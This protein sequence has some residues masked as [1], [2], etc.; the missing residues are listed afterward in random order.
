MNTEVLQQHR[1]IYLG[2]IKELID[3]NTKALMEDDL[4]P[5]FKTPPL[6]AMDTIKQKLLSLAKTY[7]IV[8]N[9]A[10]FDSVL[11][12]YRKKLVDEVKLLQEKRIAVLT[13]KIDQFDALD[14]EQIVKTLKKELVKLDKEIK[15]DS[16]EFLI[17]INEDVLLLQMDCLFQDF[18]NI[19]KVKK[20]FSKYL[21]GN[22][23]KQIIETIDMKLLVKDTTLLNVLKEQV[24]RFVF[25]T[26]NSHLFD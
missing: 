24:E 14:P 6:E 11:S 17:K 15:K 12:D 8:L 9:T 3:N 16:K 25:T 5:L 20:E 10:T 4:L 7:Q 22:Y 18:A 26:K 19:E 13:S 1:E 2:A 21:Q 23:I